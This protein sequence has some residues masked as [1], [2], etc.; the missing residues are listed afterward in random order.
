M[1]WSN[2]KIFI[3]KTLET[4]N[5]FQNELF[6]VIKNEEEIIND[7][8]QRKKLIDYKLRL[9]GGTNL[10]GISSVISRSSE[11]VNQM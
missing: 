1:D 9:Y 2:L 6:K 7:L 3:F 8:N 4:V 11:I 10:K 5:H